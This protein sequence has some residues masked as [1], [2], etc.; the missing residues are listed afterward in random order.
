MA[1]RSQIAQTAFDLA[2]P[3]VTT[4]GIDL[5]DVEY[6]KEGS[7]YFLRLFIDKR[8]GIFIDDCE[9]VSKAMDPIYDS[10]LKVKPDFF[11]VSS[12][13]LTRP[14]KTV[15]DFHRYCGEEV[16]ITLFKP[17]DAG[18]KFQGT[19]AEVIGSEIVFSVED[20]K[21]SIPLPDISLAK[22]VIHF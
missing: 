6:K 14:L 16:E 11:E 3:V 10:E 7:A 22:R 15:E 12:P 2:L 1:G 8:G 5:V 4:M 20:K 21:I 13:G 19:I 9:K 18:K 17:A